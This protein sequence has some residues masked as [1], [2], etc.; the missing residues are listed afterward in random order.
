MGPDARTAPGEVSGLA[1]TV[2]LLRQ[3]PR[4]AAGVEVLLLERPRDRGSFAGGWVFPGGAVDAEDLPGPGGVGLLDLPPAEE[5]AVSRRAAVRETREETGLALREADLV[6]LSRWSPPAEALKRLRTWFWL[7]A[8]PP[9]PIVLEPREAVG[10]RWLTPDAAL[11]LHA[12]GELRLFPPTWLTLHG[13][14]DAASVVETLQRARALARAE[15]ATRVVP[16][17]DIVLWAPD[18]AYSTGSIDPALV[19]APGPRHRLDMREL[20]WRY[21]REDWAPHRL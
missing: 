9:G 11:A 20:P 4:G 12:R 15:F 21:L 3:P 13:L 18:A 8:A 2:V 7:A 17:A 14:R 6:S 16:G 10:H 1:A 5:E 19:D